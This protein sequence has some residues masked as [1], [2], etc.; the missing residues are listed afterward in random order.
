MV[1]SFVA[2]RSYPRFVM[3]VRIYRSVSSAGAHASAGIGNHGELASAGFR[4]DHARPL[5]NVAQEALPWTLLG[6]ADHFSRGAACSSAEALKCYENPP[7]FIKMGLLR[8]ALLFTFT[9]HSAS[10]AVGRKNGLARLANRGRVHFPG[11]CGLALGWR[12]E[13]SRF[14]E[15]VAGLRDIYKT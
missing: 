14:T 2:R 7:F 6:P 11:F 8:L 15:P 3:D 4:L 13:R 5:A 1:R 12:E 9:L 10:N